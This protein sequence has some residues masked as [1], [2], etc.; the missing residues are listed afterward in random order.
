MKKKFFAIAK[1]L[2]VTIKEYKSTRL[3]D[4]GGAQMFDVRYEVGSRSFHFVDSY[5]HL[6]GDAPKVLEMFEIEASERIKKMNY[7]KG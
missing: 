2:G 6:S 4:V 1:R 3:R 5:F 7:A